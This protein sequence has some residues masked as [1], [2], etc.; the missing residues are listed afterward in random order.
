MLMDPRSSAGRDYAN[1]LSDLKYSKL[2]PSERQARVAA[3]GASLGFTNEAALQ[4]LR[5]GNQLAIDAQRERGADGR[6]ALDADVALMREMGA[7]RR[8]KQQYVT[9]SSGNLLLLDGGKA[10]DVLD[11]YGDPVRASMG[12]SGGASRRGGGSS[13]DVTGKDMYKD[14]AAGKDVAGALNSAD[15]QAYLNEL[16]SGSPLSDAGRRGE[17]ALT[18]DLGSRINDTGVLGGYGPWNGEDMVD[19]SQ[20]GNLDL[21][22]AE[23]SPESTGF[24]NLAEGLSGPGEDYYTL[25]FPGTRPAN[26]S[27]EEARRLQG[28]INLARERRIADEKARAAAEERAARR[29]KRE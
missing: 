9:D 28:P 13:G 6:A 21:G 12:G 14:F 24:Y 2:T 23:L 29:T 27:A 25:S 5:D 7:D 26:I 20:F 3:F 8:A 17:V 19:P 10:S 1:F 11:A 22:S 18:S 4:G 15:V 16:A